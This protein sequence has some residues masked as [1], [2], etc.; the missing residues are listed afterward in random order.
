MTPASPAAASSNFDFMPFL[1]LPN[2]AGRGVRAANGLFCERSKNSAEEGQH[3]L[4]LIGGR[5]H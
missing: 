1:L 2:D 3:G 5:R 4:D